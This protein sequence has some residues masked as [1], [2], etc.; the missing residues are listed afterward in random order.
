MVLVSSQI[1]WVCE[2]LKKRQIMYDTIINGYV[3]DEAVKKTMDCWLD[4]T[5]NLYD[6]YDLSLMLKCQSKLEPADIEKL[7]PHY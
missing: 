4:Y 6:F 5:G 1:L 3:G 7:K 2:H